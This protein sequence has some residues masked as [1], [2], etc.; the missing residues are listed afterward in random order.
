MEKPYLHPYQDVALLQLA[1]CMNDI[2]VPVM[3]MAEHRVY[4]NFEIA[5]FCL[6]Q[7]FQFTLLKVVANK[8]CPHLQPLDHGNF[9]AFSHR[10]SMQPGEFG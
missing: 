7:H 5:G 8:L 1:R 2:A 6:S 10:T 9:C 3:A 4:P